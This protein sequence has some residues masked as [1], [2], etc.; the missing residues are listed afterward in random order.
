MKYILFLIISMISLVRAGLADEAKLREFATTSDNLQAEVRRTLRALRYPRTIN[1]D[2]VQTPQESL[3]E[4]QARFSAWKTE[5]ETMLMDRVGIFASISIE[6]KAQLIELYFNLLAN[7]IHI[8]KTIDMQV[9]WLDWGN[10]FDLRIPKEIVWSSSRTLQGLFAQKIDVV[11]NKGETATLRLQ[12]AFVDGIQIATIA[13]QVNADSHL[14]VVKYLIYI[15]LYKQLTQNEYYRAEDEAPALPPLP[16]G[17]L[18][19]KNSYE[20]DLRQRIIDRFRSDKQ[21]SRLHVALLTSYPR[22][23]VPSTGLTMPLISNWALYEQMSAVHPNIEAL[24]TL[25]LAQQLYELLNAEQLEAIAVSDVEELHRFML[26]AEHLLLPTELGK[27]LQAM[28]VEIDG[29]RESLVALQRVLVRSRSNALLASL[30]QLRIKDR[31]KQQQLFRAVQERGQVLQGSSLQKVTRWHETAKKQLPEITQKIQL[32]LNKRLLLVAKK[33]DEIERSASEPIQLAILRK[34]LLGSL[35]VMDFSGEV[36]ESLGAVL[37]SQDYRQSRLVFFQEL[38]KHLARLS[39]TKQPK[40]LDLTRTGKD[41]IVRTY[42]NPALALLDE[43]KSV[44]VQAI[45]RKAKVNNITQIKSLI[46]YGYWLGYFT[47]KGDK[48]PTLDDLPLSEQQKESYFTELKFAYFDHYPFLLLKPKMNNPKKKELYLL[49]ADIV[50]DK[51]IETAVDD[52]QLWPLVLQTIDQQRAQI[53]TK[54]TEID[55]TKSLQEIKHLAANSPTVAM[56]IRDYSGLYPLHE[57]FVHRYHKP[58]KF[59]HNWEKINFDYIGNFFMVIIGYHL[60]GWLLRKPMFGTAGAHILQYFNP[61]F[62][63]ALQY[64]GPV[65][66]AFWGVILFEYFV[67]LPYKTFVIKPQKLKELKDYYR[68]G[69]Q[70]SYFVTGRFLDYYRQ[71]K[72][73]HFVNYAF[74]MSMHAIFVS[75]WIYSLKFSHIIPEMRENRLN[76][77]LRRVGVRETNESVYKQRGEVFNRENI[78]N[79]A[80]KAIGRI[81]GVENVSKGYIREQTRQIEKARDKIIALMDRRKHAIR[82]ATIEHKHDFAAL[83][84]KEPFFDYEAMHKIFGLIRYGYKTGVYSEA[85]YREAEIAI[86]Q[87]EVTLFRR[88]RISPLVRAGKPGQEHPYERALGE[89]MNENMFSK[90]ADDAVNRAILRFYLTAANMDTAIIKSTKDLSK[91]DEGVLTELKA[92]LEGKLPEGENPIAY[93]QSNGRF[94][95][96]IF[97]TE[98]FFTGYETKI[99]HAT[100][101]E[102]RELIIRLKVLGVKTRRI[103]SLEDVKKI[104]NE[105]SAKLGEF[106]HKY[107]PLNR[108]SDIDKRRKGDKLRRKE[109]ALQDIKKFIETGIIGRWK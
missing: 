22:I 91:I 106:R 72:N 92:K 7:L 34:S 98:G 88:L 87:I 42:V 26:L 85:V 89:A 86:R 107:K 29:S 56:G 93:F 3:T 105:I 40:I 68:L 79:E 16:D 5:L 10:Q 52:E 8:K 28:T 36:Q 102:M 101:D 55:N 19:R 64:A 73:S 35:Y 84:I 47:S 50:R 39:P 32:D 99:L 58:S 62:G 90:R 80:T 1:T 41:D 4:L 71:E 31:G 76:K 44:T 94:S 33:V 61:A 13:H 14:E 74:E 63:A 18:P 103:K 109:D 30:M 27:S 21:K 45:E 81:K 77:L 23:Q 57:E 104:E 38:K 2:T 24:T 108:D 95:D 75:W 25:G 17:F 53:E 37:Q 69:S 49:L 66:H 11:T 100:P 60:G 20:L 46:Q 67:A 78:E 12:D 51:D 6:G 15:T 70:D 83:G 43:D 48:V 59:E 97:T 65:L 9:S 82:V 96:N 54:I